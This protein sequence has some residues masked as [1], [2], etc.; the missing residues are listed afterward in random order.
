MKPTEIKT[1]TRLLPLLWQYA[2]QHLP[3]LKK[4]PGG[5]CTGIIVTLGEDVGKNQ[6]PPKLSALD[7]L[8]S[9][10]KELKA[11]PPQPVPKDPQVDLI[12]TSIIKNH[13]LE[14]L[15]RFIVAGEFCDSAF[16]EAC[17][18]LKF[19]GETLFFVSNYEDLTRETHAIAVSLM[20][21]DGRRF[22]LIEA[23]GTAPLVVGSTLRNSF[24]AET[25]NTEDVLKFVKQGLELQSGMVVSMHFR[26]FNENVR[27]VNIDKHQFCQRHLLDDLSQSEAIALRVV[28][29]WRKN[30][31]LPSFRQQELLSWAIIYDNEK[32]VHELLNIIKDDNI[33][34]NVFNS[35]ILSYP[36][37]QSLLS[38]VIPRISSDSIRLIKK[39]EVTKEDIIQTLQKLTIPQDTEKFK[40]VLKIFA[41]KDCLK[42]N[43]PQVDLLKNLVFP[44]DDELLGLMLDYGA[45]F[46][47]KN[48]HGDTIIDILVKNKLYQRGTLF[49]IFSYILRKKPTSRERIQ[50]FSEIFTANSLKIEAGKICIIS[51][52]DEKV[53]TK[54]VVDEV[55]YE[56]LSPAMRLFFYMQGSTELD[57]SKSLDK[58]ILLSAYRDKFPFERFTIDQ[59]L[60]LL[61]SAIA[62]K[63]EELASRLVDEIKN[64][65][66]LVNAFNSI[67]LDNPLK[68]YLFIPVWQRVDCHQ[69]HEF[70]LPKE[71]ILDILQK[72]EIPRCID[73]FKSCLEFFN[74]PNIL[75]GNGSQADLLVKILS[76]KIA[77][78]KL[79]DRMLGYG[80]SLIS[81]NNQ[82][83]KILDVL[84]QKKFPQIEQFLNLYQK[85]CD[86]ITGG[87]LLKDKI[88]LLMS[89]LE[90]KLT[91]VNKNKLVI[92]LLS[93]R[94]SN[95]ET[96]LQ[97]F[98]EVMQE[99][100]ISLSNSQYFLNLIHK[101]Y[102]HI[103]R[104]LNIKNVTKQQI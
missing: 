27:V 65:Q 47:A 58:N 78:E 89:V 87:V 3:D 32:L 73:R 96:N 95:N 38:V 83:Q 19:P 102:V 56:K 9:W 80:A 52:N 72:I 35:L 10:E 39:F 23:N 63:D 75:Q 71:D 81:K 21:G 28:R 4:I 26:S 85:N 24:T 7:K 42:G 14:M 82:G 55:K 92:H 50:L 77:D 103:P 64:D 15:G 11:K 43:G 37:K 51:V 44:R 1:Q 74:H 62:D 18:W 48:N 20:P 94:C 45:S 33:F 98:A 31:D 59:Q 46:N 79:L 5:L 70:K 40:S 29:G 104:K 57:K 84:D 6:L 100:K 61:S 101:I 17:E 16:Y 34:I 93:W 36:L 76:T 2:E 30:P 8:F 69:I 25:K 53:I 54:R 13:C 99:T 68:K 91:D 90:S 12:I 41:D 88:A 86:K 67:N 97:L 49:G 22:C 66:V 60:V